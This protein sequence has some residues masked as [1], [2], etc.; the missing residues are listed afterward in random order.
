[1]L[2][3]GGPTWEERHDGIDFGCFVGQRQQDRVLVDASLQ[4]PGQDGQE[5]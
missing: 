4:G 3:P 1:M 5:A 2:K